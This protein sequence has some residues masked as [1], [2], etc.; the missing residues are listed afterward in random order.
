MHYIRQPPAGLKRD[1]KHLTRRPSSQWLVTIRLLQKM[2]RVSVFG[3]RGSWRLT[4]WS[5]SSETGQQFV[6]TTSPSTVSNR[7]FLWPSD[8]FTANLKRPN[9]VIFKNVQKLKVLTHGRDMAFNANISSWQLGWLW[10]WLCPCAIKRRTF[11][12]LFRDRC[13]GEDHRPTDGEQENSHT[14]SPTSLKFINTTFQWKTSLRFFSDFRRLCESF[15]AHCNL[16]QNLNAWATLTRSKAKLFSSRLVWSEEAERFE[17]TPRKLHQTWLTLKVTLSSSSR[18]I[19]EKLFLQTG[20]TNL[21]CSRM[22]KCQ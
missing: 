17:T 8:H 18:I 22:C 20:K 9:W 6:H 16:R 1:D 15:L 19:F 12:H 4:S 13:I 5:D 7:S 3:N 21:T 11:A 10:R 2:L 14:L